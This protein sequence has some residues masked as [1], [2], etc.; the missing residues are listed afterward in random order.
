M[1]NFLISDFEW[2]DESL[3]SPL[4]AIILLQSS[5]LN[6]VSEFWLQIRSIP[7]TT[8]LVIL[9]KTIGRNQTKKIRK[10]S[11]RQNRFTRICIIYKLSQKP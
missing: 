8:I 6:V 4:E 11:F 9:F 10:T 5:I 7:Y 2:I 3:K 1:L